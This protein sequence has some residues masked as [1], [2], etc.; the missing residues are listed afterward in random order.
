MMT[1]ARLEAFTD[2]VVA[3]VLTVLVL[4][5][6]IP[7]SPSLYS[8]LNISNTL[9]AYTVSFIFVAVIWVNHHR[10]MQMAEKINYSVI[11]AN[12][13]WLF[14][15]TLCPAVTSWVGRNP[16]R[17]W[18]EFFYVVVYMMWSF[19]YGILS[20]KVI[21]ANDPNS[22]VAIVLSR[23]RRSQISMIINLILLVGV[24]FY[25]PFGM[26]GRFFVSAIWIVSYRTANEY[27]Q[28]VRQLFF[29]S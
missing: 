11:W 5:I 20:K 17:F 3:I 7:D 26:I 4:D 2:G 25:P 15:L 8:I 14:W 9:L 10:M 27:F 13:F 6:Q 18:P 23:D 24:F 1:K 28:K 29:K 19:S 12:I 21:K 22:H 16:D